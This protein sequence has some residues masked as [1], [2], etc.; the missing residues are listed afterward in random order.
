MACCILGQH[1][2]HGVLVSAK[3]R[4]WIDFYQVSGSIERSKDLEDPLAHKQHLEILWFASIDSLM[5]QLCRNDAVTFYCSHFARAWIVLV[6]W[7]WRIVYL[8][9]R[10]HEGDHSQCRIYKETRLEHHQQ[11][12]IHQ[13]LNSF[14]QSLL[15]QFH[16]AIII[17]TYYA[18]KQRHIYHRSQTWLSQ[19]RSSWTILS[20]EAFAIQYFQP[21]ILRKIH[22]YKYRVSL[23]LNNLPCYW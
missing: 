2:S 6:S 20:S 8:S 19:V 22:Y 12:H 5:R 9:K 13:N 15:L 17:S 7:A 14:R 10:S 16:K 23:Y 3:P 21:W 1:W 11:I 18:L 4:P